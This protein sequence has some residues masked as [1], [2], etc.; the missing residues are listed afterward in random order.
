MKAV[1]DIWKGE[2]KLTV[3]HLDWFIHVEVGLHDILYISFIYLPVVQ[4]PYLTFI[5][6]F[7]PTPCQQ[8]AKVHHQGE[9]GAEGGAEVDQGPGENLQCQWYVI[10]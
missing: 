1:I 9:A 4:N 2:Y 10:F 7:S 6:S 5:L 3:T 8:Q